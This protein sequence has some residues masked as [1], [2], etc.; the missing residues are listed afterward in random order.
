MKTALYICILLAALVIVPTMSNI[1]LA[2]TQGF[3][4][5]LCFQK[6]SFLKPGIDNDS[7]HAYYDKCV[8]TC[9]L[10]FQ[11]GFD[12]NSERMEKRL[13]KTD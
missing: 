10:K 12:K 1:V 9:D 11:G 2:Q 3:N 8:S 6:C 7:Q 13:H 5:E 4:H